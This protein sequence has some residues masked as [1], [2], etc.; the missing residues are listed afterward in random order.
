MVET[1][2]G[3]SKAEAQAILDKVADDEPVFLLRG[4]DLTFAA[5]VEYWCSLVQQLALSEATK[6]KAFARQTV[7]STGVAWWRRANAERIK[8]PD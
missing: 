4:Q 8:L 5:V 7:L 6:E 3:F 1:I 2:P